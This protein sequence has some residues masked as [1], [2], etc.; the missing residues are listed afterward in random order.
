MKAILIIIISLLIAILFIYN[1]QNNVEH[2]SIGNNDPKKKKNKHNKDN[3]PNKPKKPAEQIQYKSDYTE[4]E[5]VSDS[6]VNT[7]NSNLCSVYYVPPSLVEE[8]DRGIFQLTNKKLNL[9]Y[10]KHKHKYKEIMN[11]KKNLPEPN[12]CKINLQNWKTTS[13]APIINFNDPTNSNRG[14]LSSW[15]FCYQDITNEPDLINTITKSLEDNNATSIQ[16]NPQPL[17]GIF[18]DTLSYARLA[19]KKLDFTDVKR[20]VCSNINISNNMNI[21]GDFLG[22]TLNIDNTMITETAV[23]SYNIE[24]NKMDVKQ[25]QTENLKIIIGNLVE[26]RLDPVKDKPDLYQHVIAPVSRDTRI[27][28]FEQN[29]CGSPSLGVMING[30]LNLSDF[31]IKT[32]NLGASA[33][34]TDDTYGFD[35]DIVEKREQYRDAI[36]TATNLKIRE[37]NKKNMRR[38]DAVLRQ[39]EKDRAHAYNTYINIITKRNVL[40]YN[41]ENGKGL[42]PD[43]KSFDN[44]IYIEI[45]PSPEQIKSLS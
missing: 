6:T 2:F 27:Y 31:G 9:R 24:K 26:E 1:I 14:P 21:S 41:T 32:M 37:R 4:S 11:A 5:S 17:T 30:I 25:P 38:L 44:R 40:P 10:Q 16:I 28:K 33:K 39:I 22:F 29:I 42:P 36:D 18:G 23:Y 20:D 8:C 43:Y 12:I 3:K 13:E 45:L 7:I 19:F 34:E 35:K 15:S